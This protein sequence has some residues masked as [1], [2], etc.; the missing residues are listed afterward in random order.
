MLQRVAVCCR[1]LQCACSVLQ[2][3]APMWH[4][5]FTWPATHLQHTATHLQHRP[6]SATTRWDVRNHSHTATHL[7]HACNKLQRNCKSV[8]CEY[9]WLL[10][11]NSGCAGL[12][13]E[14]WP[15]R[16]SMAPLQKK[17]CNFLKITFCFIS[18]ILQL[19][20]QYGAYIYIHIYVYTYI[21]ICIYYMIYMGYM[22]IHIYVFIYYV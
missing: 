19:L 21:Y 7:Q 10:L 18:A 9:F 20:A 11:V 13:A 1:G 6:L 2:C 5:L 3:V 17:K 14:T 8:S 12:R 4:V 22:Y 15:A 16:P